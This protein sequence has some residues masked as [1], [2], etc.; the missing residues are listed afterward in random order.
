MR[1]FVVLG[2]LWLGVLAPTV[3]ADLQPDYFE[4]CMIEYAMADLAL[5]DEQEALAD[6]I[7][8]IP[9][10]LLEVLIEL[11]LQERFIEAAFAIAEAAF[12]EE[13]YLDALWYITDARADLFFAQTNW[14]QMVVM[15]NQLDVGHPLQYYPGGTRVSFASLGLRTQNGIQNAHDAVTAAGQLEATARLFLN[16]LDDL[17]EEADA[18]LDANQASLDALAEYWSCVSPQ[19]GR[20]IGIVTANL[21]V[22]TS[23]AENGVVLLRTHPSFGGRDVTL[24]L[25]NS[26]RSESEGKVSR[27]LYI[28]YEIPADAVFAEF[29]YGSRGEILATPGNPLAVK[30]THE[31]SIPSYAMFAGVFESRGNPLTLNTEI[32]GLPLGSTC[33][34]DH[35]DRL[36]AGQAD[37]CPTFLETTGTP[38]QIA[39]GEQVTDAFHVLSLGGDLEQSFGSHY[40]RFRMVLKADYEAPTDPCYPWDPV[41]NAYVFDQ[42]SV[43]CGIGNGGN[44]GGGAGGN[45]GPGALTKLVPTPD[46]ISTPTPGEGRDKTTRGAVAAQH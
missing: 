26:I 4:D 6:I 1:R 29:V 2:I 38:Q 25:S 39:N 43:G 23:P 45:G 44:G 3:H 28:G 27:S 9:D 15:A 18:V 41:A 32:P 16:Y 19:A 24:D 37:S 14:V 36:L 20:I 30:S 12:L 7:D 31:D 33:A 22:R 8:K 21:H 17:E 42:F 5:A 13:L 11:E 40:M 35:P 10:E 34:G 46:P